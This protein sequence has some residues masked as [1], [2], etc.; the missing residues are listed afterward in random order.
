MWPE[1][2]FPGSG[3]VFLKICQYV[4]ANAQ[5]CL[6]SFAATVGCMVAVF[7]AKTIY[8]ILPQQ[9]QHIITYIYVYIIY[10][11]IIYT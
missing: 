7:G 3:S 10:R 2:R 6:G 1:N 8:L 11:F 9:L 4:Y 5:A